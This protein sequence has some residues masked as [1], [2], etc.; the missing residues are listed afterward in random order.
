MRRYMWPLIETYW[1]YHVEVILSVSH[2]TTIL[3]HRGLTLHLTTFIPDDSNDKIQRKSQRT[4]KNK[5]KNPHKLKK[6]SHATYQCLLS[7]IQEADTAMLVADV[8]EFH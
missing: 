5:I 3:S 6:I 4:N 2:Q 1:Y 8:L 7:P